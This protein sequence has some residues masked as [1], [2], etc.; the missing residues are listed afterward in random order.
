MTEKSI[1]ISRRR[2]MKLAA[3]G[4]IAIPFGG[5]LVGNAMAEDLV[6]LPDDDPQAAAL[7]YVADATKATRADKAGTPGSEQT[8]ESCM[9]APTPGGEQ[10]ACQL[11]PGKSVAA[12]GWCSSWA[13]RPA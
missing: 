7:K 9:L 3:G 2:A 1:D 10:I 12:A 8:C 6:P 4:V 13:L 11:F 5:M